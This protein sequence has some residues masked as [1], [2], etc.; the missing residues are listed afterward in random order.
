MHGKKGNYL[1][2]YIYLLSSFFFFFKSFLSKPLK[3]NKFPFYFLQMYIIFD[4]RNQ[5]GKKKIVKNLGKLSAAS[6][7]L[8]HPNCRPI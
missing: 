3:F 2:V 4:H 6:F 7:I 1:K 5:M 8:F